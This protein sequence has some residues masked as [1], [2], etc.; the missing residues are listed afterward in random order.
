MRHTRHACGL[1]V[2]RCDSA[3]RTR[4]TRLQ[5]TPALSFIVDSVWPAVSAQATVDLVEDIA[6]QF[7]TDVVHGA[8]AAAATRNPGAPGGGSSSSAAKKD[9]LRLDDL[10]YAVRRDPRKVARIQVR[11]CERRGAAELSR[12]T[13]T[14]LQEL[15]R[16]RAT[17]ACTRTHAH[18]CTHSE[19]LPV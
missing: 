5:Q 3:V 8:M 6:L 1:R 7:I 16:C 14:P 4:P 15:T 2:C 18:A 19:R 12:V 9:E 13:A 17:S 10:L 11:C